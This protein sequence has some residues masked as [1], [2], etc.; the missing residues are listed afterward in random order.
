MEVLGNGGGERATQ[1]DAPRAVGDGPESQGKATKHRERSYTAGLRCSSPQLGKWLEEIRVF[2]ASKPV[3]SSGWPL[4]GFH[5]IKRKE[6]FV[7]KLS[8]SQGLGALVE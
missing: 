2:T 8:C 6:I 3:R 1:Q 5:D 7:S 4:T